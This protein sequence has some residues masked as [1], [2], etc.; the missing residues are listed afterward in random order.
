MNQ[1]QSEKDKIIQNLKNREIELTD[2]VDELNQK[3]EL[4]HKEEML[5]NLE[6]KLKGVMELLKV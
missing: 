6:N 5:V 3:I 4:S 1:K 2:Q